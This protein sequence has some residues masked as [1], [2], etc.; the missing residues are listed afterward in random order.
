MTTPFDH[1][2]E[3]VSQLTVGQHY[4]QLFCRLYKTYQAKNSEQ[5]A[6]VSQNWQILSTDKTIVI[7]RNKGKQLESS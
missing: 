7:Q 5:A 2:R 3:A 4:M 1:F 6:S